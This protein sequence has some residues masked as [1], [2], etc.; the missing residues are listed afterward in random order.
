MVD[1]A[2]RPSTREPMPRG[3]SRRF[4]NQEIAM[5]QQLR[6]GATAF[7]LLASISLASAQ[8]GQAADQPLT[9]QQQQSVNQGLANQPTD[10]APAGYQGQVGSKMPDSMSAHPMPNSVASDVPETK[11][12][13]FVKLPD[14]VLLIDPDSKAIAEILLAGDTTGS[15]SDQQNQQNQQK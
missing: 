15:T 10:S 3:P 12:L 14:R 4:Q 2:R 5:R 8:R 13:L 6:A 11:N 9:Q 7:A 1:F